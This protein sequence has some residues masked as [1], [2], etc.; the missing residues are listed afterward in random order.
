MSDPSLNVDWT[1]AER[2]REA[3]S[4]VSLGRLYVPIGHD[5]ADIEF[6]PFGLDVNDPSIFRLGWEFAMPDTSTGKN[7][8]AFANG[9]LRYER[10]GNR[11]ILKNLD[12]FGQVVRAQHAA[13][14]MPRPGWL[15]Y[16]GVDEALTLSAI[17]TLL[18]SRGHSRRA[19]DVIWGTSVPT[20]DLLQW[21]LHGTLEVPVAA[22]DTIGV[23]GN[24]SGAARRYRFSVQS[25]LDNPEGLFIDPA[26]YVSFWPQSF[27]NLSDH[28]LQNT[29]N[30]VHHGLVATGRMRYVS[31]AGGNQE[32]YDTPL[33]AAIAVKDALSEADDYDTVVILDQEIYTEGEIEINKPLNLTSLSLGLVTAVGGPSQRPTLDGGNQNRVMRVQVSD[34]VVSLTSLAIARGALDVSPLAGEDTGAWHGT[35]PAGGAGLLVDKSPN[36]FVSNCHIHHNSV[37]GHEGFGLALPAAEVLGVTEHGFGGG[38]LAFHSSPIISDCLICDNSV[39]RRGGGV[40]IWGYGWPALIRNH[41]LRNSATE[42]DGGGVA[43]EIAVP[44][45]VWSGAVLAIVG[46]WDMAFPDDII[47]TAK[48]SSLKFFDNVISNNTAGDDGGGFYLSVLTG[49]VFGRNRIEHNRAGGNGGGLRTS[50]GTWVIMEGDVV[51]NNESNSAMVP[52]ALTGGGGIAAR[53]SDLFLKDVRIVDNDA[54]A[55]AGGGLLF[56]ASEEGGVVRTSVRAWTYDAILQDKYKK[57]Q[58]RLRIESSCQISGNRS[59]A[60]L[61]AHPERI[62]GGGVYIFRFAAGSFVALPIAIVIEDITAI[63]GNVLDAQPAVV[64]PDS[65]ELFLDDQ[66]ERRDQPVDSSNIHLFLTGEGF[67]YRSADS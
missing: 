58:V 51:A 39:Q 21:F 31:K 43:S 57:T 52:D 20:L 32:P 24:V 2:L 64:F 40:G 30:R 41:I 11:L 33:K 56:A 35:T 61:D 10:N 19:L 34:G 53:N 13:T 55:F 42:K 50:L 3:L 65:V 60:I 1:V 27:G 7:L 48:Q 67:I 44:Y 46:T 9:A 29:M 16:N 26:A 23:A 5:A 63:S 8:L 28:P 4:A 49:A 14:W 54:W 45:N 47:A 18:G 17:E 59:M 25:H 37:I 38:I 6:I 12:P 62:K 66:V 15:I 36:T 22:G